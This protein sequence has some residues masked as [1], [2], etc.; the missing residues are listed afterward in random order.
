M[1]TTRMLAKQQR[2]ARRLAKQQ[3]TARRLVKQQ[4]TARRLAK[5]QRTARRLAKQQ[6]TARRLAKQQRTARR[7]RRAVKSWQMVW[8]AAHRKG[9]QV[10]RLRVGVDVGG[11]FTDIV[12]WDEGSE[13]LHVLQTPSV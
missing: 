10:S 2:T 3:R 11:T 1:L 6:R 12:I 5:Q 9:R 4:R 8:G 13:R 7:P